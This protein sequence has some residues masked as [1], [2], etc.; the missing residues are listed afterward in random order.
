NIQFAKQ[1]ENEK[2]RFFMHDMR[3]LLYINYFDFAF[4]LFTSFGYFNSDKEHIKALKS[5]NR[6]LKKNGI[7]VLDYFNREKILHNLVGQEIKVIEGIEFHITK[8]IEGDKIIKT[9]T[10]EHR[11]KKFS[12]REEVKAFSMEDF[13]RLFDAAGFEIGSYFGDYALNEYDEDKSDRIV[14]ICRKK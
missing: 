10:F 1:F 13:K 11:K 14:F 4:N 5:F 2:L 12:F 3:H 9:I 7:L 6:S 8:K